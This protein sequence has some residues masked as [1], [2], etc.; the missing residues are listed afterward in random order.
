M[1]LQA[2]R[3]VIY[4]KC[5]AFKCLPLSIYHFLSAVQKRMA[6]RIDGVYDPG[7]IRSDHCTMAI[8]LPSAEEGASNE[9]A[10]ESKD[11]KEIINLVN[12]VPRYLLVFGLMCALFCVSF[13]SL[14][15]FPSSR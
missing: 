1:T 2:V 10:V 4:F 11:K 7:T 12:G 8:D 14:P 6:D 3:N 5:L 9:A 15:Y 13:V